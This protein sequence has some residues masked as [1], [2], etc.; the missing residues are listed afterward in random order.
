VPLPRPL[1]DPLVDLLAERFGVLAQPLRIKLIDRLDERGEA[2]VQEL[3]EVLEAGQQNVSKHL[4]VLHRAGVVARRKD[5]IFVRYRLVDR[6][7]L[8]LFEE[9]A[10]AI[11][12]RLR[13]Q[14]RLV[15][16]EPPS[17]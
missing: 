16:P 4:G 3:A 7:S 14:A 5:G 15:G 9:S 6:E 2:T 10:A 8:T 1:P 13:R 12:R 11:V 17:R